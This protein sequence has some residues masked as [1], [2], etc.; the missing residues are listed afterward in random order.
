MFDLLLPIFGARVD[1]ILVNRKGY[2]VDHTRKGVPLVLAQ[3]NAMVRG[4]RV[5]FRDV[6]LAV[7]YVD[8]LYAQHGGL[9]DDGLNGNLGRLEVPVGVRGNAKLDSLARASRRGRSRDRK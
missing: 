2:Q 8:A 9:V 6:H 3:V 7:H 1:E 4:Q 5:L